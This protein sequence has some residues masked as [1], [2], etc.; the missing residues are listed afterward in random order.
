MISQR[1]IRQ[2]IYIVDNSGIVDAINEIRSGGGDGRRGRPA[3]LTSTRPFFV[4]LFIGLAHQGTARIT[5]LHHI[6]TRDLDEQTQIDLGIRRVCY[7]DCGLRCDSV[8]A[9]TQ[10]DTVSELITAKMNYSVEREPDL[11]DDERSERHDRIIRIADGLM[12]VFQT[13]FNWESNMVAIDA[14]GI[15]AW[16]KSSS[17]TQ[18]QRQAERARRSRQTKKVK[19]AKQSAAAA[20]KPDTPTVDSDTPFNTDDDPA[21]VEIID[22][23]DLPEEFRAILEQADAD[24]VE[25]RRAAQA[26]AVTS[27][28]VANPGRRAPRLADPD[29]KHAGKTGK[30]GRTQWFFG[31]FLHVINQTTGNGNGEAQPSLALRYEVDRATTAGT[32][33]L[34]LSILDRARVGRPIRRL[35]A[36]R[37]YS[38]LRVETWRDELATRSIDP[39]MDMRSTDHGVHYDDKMIV[40]DGTY[41]CPGM[42]TDDSVTMITRPGP[43]NK[44]ADD[45]QEFHDAIQ[46]RS[47]FQLV[48]HTAIGT[49]G[50]RRYKCPARCGQVGCPLVEDSMQ[51]ALSTQ[52]MPLVEHAPT[53]PEAL[54]R[55]CT[56]Q[57][58]LVRPDAISR[59][60]HQEHPWGGPEWERLWAQR[61]SVEALFG[62]IKNDSKIS[63]RRGNYQVGGLAWMNILSGFALSAANL[64]L[65]NN[66]DTA[67]NAAG[68]TPIDHPLL[69]RHVREP[70]VMRAVYADEPKQAA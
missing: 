14:T 24:V 26:D 42:S 43:T 51:I 61:S 39:V 15:W 7:D 60:H 8:M 10:F 55:I 49:D 63:L 64:T 13:G 45:W 32:A 36:D 23:E 57:T 66:W 20:T 70:I 12:D 30:D 22:L 21:L 2:A 47:P 33:E 27:A 11:S 65:L 5:D 3:D 19:N 18:A 59:K 53:G 54:P 25:K 56:Q 6:A 46:R 44:N 62:I 69:P 1:L 67:R 28:K 35:V 34:T 41:H 29:A 38:N 40:I 37:L 52:G 48:P 31:Y 16:T 9:K 17:L 4:S 50:S 68:M 58:V